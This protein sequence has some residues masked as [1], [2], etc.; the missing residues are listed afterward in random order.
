MKIELWC[1]CFV[2]LGVELMLNFRTFP[3][4]S[5]RHVISYRRN[6][7]DQL[8]LFHFPLA[9]EQLLAFCPCGNCVAFDQDIQ[10]Q[11]PCSVREQS[12][13]REGCVLLSNWLPAGIEERALAES[14]ES[15]QQWNDTD[16]TY[17][18]VKVG[19]YQSQLKMS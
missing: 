16:F 13:S 4:V 5:S 15:A 6:L 19:N 3:L 10:S 18:S 14:A 17:G 12:Y 1:R 7:I 2:Y 8:L 9:E 11:D